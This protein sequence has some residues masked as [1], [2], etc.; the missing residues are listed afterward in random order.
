MEGSAIRIVRLCLTLAMTDEAV[1]PGRAEVRPM[2]GLG[3]S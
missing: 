1:I 2:G 3:L